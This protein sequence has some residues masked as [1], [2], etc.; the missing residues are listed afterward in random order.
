MSMTSK[1][2]REYSDALL[3]PITSQAV[4]LAARFR[5]FSALF[6]CMKRGGLLK[7][8]SAVVWPSVFYIY[9][10]S[11]VAIVQTLGAIIG[12]GARKEL[13]LTHHSTSGRHVNDTTP[14]VTETGC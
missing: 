1:P 3:S 14:E 2:N 7:L 5:V 9:I 11:C 4:C 13:H 6:N 10:E 12:G 8:A